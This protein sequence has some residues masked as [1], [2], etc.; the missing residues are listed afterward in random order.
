MTGGR[1]SV[2]TTAVTVFPSSRWTTT[3]RRAGR[4]RPAQA[5]PQQMHFDLMVEDLDQG[6]A[7]VLGLGGTKAE[8]QPG[9]TFRVFLDPASHPFCLCVE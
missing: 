7:V 8:V 4:P 6:E 2:P 1:T 5:G 9:T 3:N